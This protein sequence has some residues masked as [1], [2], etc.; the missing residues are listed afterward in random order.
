MNP[1][2][3]KTILAFPC[4]PDLVA[5]FLARVDGR[6]ASAL[7][8]AK[9]AP[10]LLPVLRT[11]GLTD[12]HVLPET[13][14]GRVTQEETC[15]A[16]ARL[17]DLGARR[18]YFPISDF[19]G[20]SVPLL[21][22]LSE[23]VTAVNAT[24]MADV[25]ETAEVPVADAVCD[26]RLPA[27]LDGL[28]A[29]IVG[30]L[31]AAEPT[32]RNMAGGG[33]GGEKPTT[34]LL[35]GFPYDSETLY[36]YAV[37]PADKL[38]ARVLEIGCGLGFGAY[39]LSRLHPERTFVVSDIDEAAIATARE[40]WQGQ[41]NLDF[42]HC[43]GGRLPQSE[44]AF[45]SVL[46]YELIEH[47]DAPAALLRECCA[48]LRPGGHLIG[49]TPVS[50][51]FAYRVNTTG[52][53]DA[54][55]RSEGIWPWHLQEFDEDS[56]AGLL[57]GNGFTGVEVAYPT[58]EA[59]LDLFGRMKGRDFAANLGDLKSLAWNAS[60][61]GLRGQRVPCF[62]GSSFVFCGRKP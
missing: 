3:G 52:R 34:G 53:A 46:A 9:Q 14:Y 10:A 12:F 30:R 21:G 60:D 23:Q 55:L 44:G 15:L 29:E 7:L 51:L 24:S 59:G 57:R 49:S 20:N 42:V 27:N 33:R 35:D 19:C 61:F 32:L 39:L 16:L 4:A 26:R 25:R 17:K 13:M 48:M 45:D 40:I 6:G 5:G 38:G 22:L 58:Y 8:L 41:D 47:V 1:H 2:G 43:P 54:G 50:S 18:A 36:R 62:S 28:Q 31:R 37:T 11:H 56:L